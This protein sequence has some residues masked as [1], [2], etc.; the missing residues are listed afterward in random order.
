MGAFCAA[1]FGIALLGT[2]PNILSQPIT[3]SPPPRE[4]SKQPFD[5]FSIWNTPIGRGA[6]YQ[7]NTG[8]ETLMLRDE[9]VGG[10]AGSYTWIGANAFG[11]YQQT[12]GNPQ[13]RWS[14]LSRPATLPW[15]HEGGLPDG[16]FLL[17]TPPETRFLGGA[18]GYAVI[19][20]QDGRFAYEVW[21]G[22]FDW[23]AQI[24]RAHYLVRT[25]LYGSGI[26][27]RDG[28]SEGIRAFGGSLLGGLIRCYELDALSIQHAIAMVPSTTQLKAGPTMNEQKV[29]PATTTD[30]DSVNIYSGLI[31]MG[32]LFAIPPSTDLTRIGLSPEGLA[33]ARAFQN[34]GG[35]VVD[36]AHKTMILAE[37]EA[38]C[39][40]AHIKNL[41][42]DKRKIVSVLTLVENNSAAEPGGPGERIASPPP[43]LRI[44]EDAKPTK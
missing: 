35:Y 33:L 14:Y 39:N 24:Y 25:D 36:T 38:G 22:S 34:F 32:A 40:S 10:H 1:G 26:S 42:Q 7:S 16:E 31:P 8:P 43:P 29:W 23:M 41:N 28:I 6:I 21:K 4:A 18:D 44:R 17:Q 19:I 27:S 37:V 11:I 5:S 2:V 3:S 15:P 20:T 13:M 12:E 30:G 9:N